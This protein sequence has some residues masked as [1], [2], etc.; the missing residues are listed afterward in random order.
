MQSVASEIKADSDYVSGK[1]IFGSSQHS[2]EE[3]VNSI[4][5]K[6]TDI[7]DTL[8]MPLAEDRMIFDSTANFGYDSHNQDSRSFNINFSNTLD[9]DKESSK[10][11]KKS[12]SSEEDKALPTTPSSPKK[13]REIQWDLSKSA[14]Y[15]DGLREMMNYAAEEHETIKITSCF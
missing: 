11:S 4:S 9:E 14:E 6:L 15:S 2:L 1:N 10:H 3:D 5:Q 12:D 7:I 8:A 13:S